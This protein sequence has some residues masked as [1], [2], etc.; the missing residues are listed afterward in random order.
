[1]GRAPCGVILGLL[2]AAMPAAAQTP[3]DTVIGTGMLQLVVPPL[4]EPVAFTFD[5]HSGPS[6]EG[7][8]GQV[9]IGDFFVGATPTCLAVRILPTNP[10][11]AAATMNVVTSAFGLVTIEVTDGAPESMPDFVA[12]D[13]A[14]TRNPVDC[15]PLPFT[16]QE[17]RA[18]V[19]AG[20]IAIVDAPAGPVSTADCKHGGWRH[21]ADFTSQGAC[22]RFLRSRRPV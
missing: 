12:S 20:D 8:T 5:V 17:T 11:V 16:N 19:L 2:L 3:E 7:P 9:T 1:M 14:S 22:V 15:S 6:G 18:T 4:P 10:P 13:L 21:F